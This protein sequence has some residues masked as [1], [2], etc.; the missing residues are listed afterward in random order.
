[1]DN[2]VSIS[3]DNIT[4]NINKDILNIVLKE[5]NKCN[6][7]CKPSRDYKECIRNCKL[8]ALQYYSS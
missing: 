5:F 3:V 8:I 1:M 6:V 4:F 2:K 7:Q